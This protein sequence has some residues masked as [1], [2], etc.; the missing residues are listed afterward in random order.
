VLPTNNYGFK[1]NLEH[2]LRESLLSVAGQ[3]QEFLPP[4]AKELA[5]EAA[6]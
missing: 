2:L 4:Q 6:D 1:K 3:C 5:C